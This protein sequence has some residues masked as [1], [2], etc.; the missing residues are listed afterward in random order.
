MADDNSTGDKAVWGLLGLAVGA[1]TMYVLA[2]ENIYRPNPVEDVEV[3]G[4]TGDVN[5]LHY[6]GGVVSKQGDSDPQW[7]WWDEPPDS[8]HPEGHTYTA[9]WA[10]VPD[11][12][13]EE[14]DWADLHALARSTGQDVDDMRAMA[15]SSNPLDRVSVMEA[16]VFFYGPIELDMYPEKYSYADLVRM[17]P[18]FA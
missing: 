16:I 4:T 18:M 13:F 8:D 15:K 2:K 12:V 11:D 5:A 17:W 1:G 7:M 14:Y 6:G 9:Y 3:L 10:D